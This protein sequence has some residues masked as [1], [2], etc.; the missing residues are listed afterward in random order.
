[1][2]TAAAAAKQCSALYAPGVKQGD[3]S[4][5]YLMPPLGAVQTIY[6]VYT[7]NPST[8]LGTQAN[9]QVPA[10]AG[11]GP[12]ATLSAPTSGGAVSADAKAGGGTAPYTY[13]WSSSSTVI[14]DNMDPDIK[15]VRAPRDGKLAGETLTLTV[16]DANGLTSTAAA[17]F[18][19][20][21]SVSAAST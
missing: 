1:I 14:T 18:A 10:V 8:D 6:P 9:L 2:I 3:P 4:L 5:G 17:S 11:A 7:C 16:T 21:G 19:G 15:Y 20:D 13:K 12:R